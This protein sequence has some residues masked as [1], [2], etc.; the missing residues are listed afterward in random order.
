MIC[1]E[2]GRSYTLKEASCAILGVPEFPKTPEDL[3]LNLYLPPE[4]L[5]NLATSILDTNLDGRERSQR[6]Y[7]SSFRNTP[8]ATAVDIGTQS[9]TGYKSTAI[10][11]FDVLLGRTA[12][13]A[14]HTHW[15]E[16]PYQKQF[17][18]RDIANNA[19]S[20]ELIDIL[21]TSSGISALVATKQSCRKNFQ[22][23]A[24]MLLRSMSRERQLAKLNPVCMYHWR[25]GVTMEKFGL[26]YYFKPLSNIAEDSFSRGITVSLN[27]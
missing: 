12:L 13:A 26:G 4:I 24:I 21:G 6:V 22:G 7:W 16:H 1:S 19:H 25:F 10:R 15:V 3:P 11:T 14:Y 17:S 8:K 18:E 20:V 27:H 2:K 9:H 5:G 23:S